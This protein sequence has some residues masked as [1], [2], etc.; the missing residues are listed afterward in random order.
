MIVKKLSLTNFRG[1]RQADFEF[2]PGVN[3]IAGVNGAGKSSILDALRVLLQLWV[4]EYVPGRHDKP[5]VQTDDIR[6]GED[7]VDISAVV[8]YSGNEYK[9][10]VHTTREKT[11]PDDLGNVSSESRV[12]P[13]IYEVSWSTAFR[14][15]IA[16]ELGNAAP[17]ALYFSPRRSQLR[18]SRAS[19]TGKKV[20]EAIYANAL[21]DRETNINAIAG[22]WSIHKSL[23]LEDK[24]GIY[25]LRMLSLEKALDSFAPEIAN[26]SPKVNI[27]GWKSNP[28][29]P[30]GRRSPIISVSLQV[31]KG[32]NIL[33]ASQLSDGERSMLALVLDI[34]RCLT[35]ANSESNDPIREGK[36]IILIDEI[37]LHLHPKWQREI[38]QR[39]ER[40]FPNCQF[41]VT[42]HSPLVMSQ[43]HA[44]RI[45][46]IGQDGVTRQPSST[47]GVPVEEI[48]EGVQDTPSPHLETIDALM[49]ALEDFDVETAEEILAGLRE[50][51]ETPNRLI[52]RL[53]T[54]IGNTR[55]LIASA[56]Q[57]AEGE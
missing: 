6:F 53:A 36:A 48:L 52:S 38:V 49:A 42:T 21:A 18:T 20:A 25:A 50:R 30:E 8:G 24:G 28:K 7:A 26:V 11:I 32:A 29:E 1:F 12:T 10:F 43:V 34:A 5:R 41:I 9:C 40:T 15:A 47:F 31:A 55:A 56:V 14:T 44:D 33:R 39:L 17:I 27:T 37:E 51:V 23:A 3:V 13:D 16:I 19:P 57:E 4:A 45:T 35:V 22:W 54:M 46:I 2:Q